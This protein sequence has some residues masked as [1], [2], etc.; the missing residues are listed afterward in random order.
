[1]ATQ[2]PAGLA[3][4]MAAARNIANAQIAAAQKKSVL[5]NRSAAKSAIPK[6]QPVQQPKPTVKER[7]EAVGDVLNP[8]SNQP[9]YIT[10]PFTGETY[11]SLDVGGSVRSIVRVSQAALALPIAAKATSFLST[12]AAT[13]GP[14]AA[15]KLPAWLIPAGIGAGA[16]LAVGAGLF[17]GSRASNA[18]QSLVQRPQQD[19]Q[20]TQ[21]TNPSIFSQDYS[22]NQQYQTYSIMDSPGASIWG[23][24]SQDRPISQVTSPYQQ[25][26][27]QQYLSGSQSQEATTGTNWGLIAAAVAAVIILAR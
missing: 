4:A 14:T 9:I 27:P 26:T 6:P 1:M 2:A 21:T 22:Q 16:G 24:Q 20:A 15:A 7:L 17:G 11:T 18:P 19:T 23:N 13:T 3:Q 5:S 25:Q 12:K 8:F 10:N